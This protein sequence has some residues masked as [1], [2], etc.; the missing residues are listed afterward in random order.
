M[1]S[2]VRNNDNRINELELA[3]VQENKPVDCPLNHR[4]TPGLYSREIFMPAGTL[5]TSKTHLTEHQFVI[6]M[7]VVMVCIDGG[8]WIRYV[9]PFVGITKAGTRRILY[10]EQDCLWITFH[11]NADDEENIEVLEK[12]LVEFYNPL[13][14]NLNELT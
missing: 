10:I 1:E 13:L 11:P 2:I 3:M 8:E 12:R 14:N 6:A 7:G 9:A 4:F 5:L